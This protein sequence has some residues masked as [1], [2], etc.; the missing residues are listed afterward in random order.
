MKVLE[1]NEHLYLFRYIQQRGV[2]SETCNLRLDGQIIMA[3]DLLNLS[4]C[5]IAK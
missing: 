1:N 2:H 3:F 5:R 4:P